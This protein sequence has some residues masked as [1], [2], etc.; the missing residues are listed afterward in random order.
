MLHVEVL[1]TQWLIERKKSLISSAET[2]LLSLFQSGHHPIRKLER[3]HDN[4]RSKFKVPY[5][6]YSW[7]FVTEFVSLVFCILIFYV[8]VVRFRVELVRI[9]N[10]SIPITLPSLQYSRLHIKKNSPMSSPSPLVFHFQTQ[11]L[12]LLRRLLLLCFRFTGAFSL[13]PALRPF[14]PAVLAEPE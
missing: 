1:A 12:L 11:A 3:G 7:V 9:I 6:F 10:T 2:H 4:Q 14:V 8:M 5:S 13:H